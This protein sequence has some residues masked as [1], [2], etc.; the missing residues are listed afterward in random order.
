MTRWSA[1][2]EPAA[3]AATA[4][5]P[6]GAHIDMKPTNS[7]AS[8][9]MWAGIS[10]AGRIVL[11]LLATAA[12]SR[13]LPPTDFGL[14]AMATIVINFANLLRDMGTSAAVIQR[15]TLSGELLDSVFWFNIALGVGLAFSV[16]LLAAPVAF[17]F[18]EARLTGVLAALAI[19]FPL[20]SSGA[21]HQALL[22]RGMRFRQL[23]RIE[24]SSAA[25]ALLAA[26]IAARHGLG[27]YSL[28]LNTV[29]LAALTTLQL[30]LASRWRPTTRWHGNELRSLWGFSANL[31]GS[32]TLTYFTRNIDTML[33]GRF[34]GALQLGWYNTAYRIMLF[35]VTNLSSVIARVLF[36]V[37][38]RRQDNVAAFT[39]LYL[40]AIS[41]IALITAPL[42]TGIWATRTQFVTVVLGE[43]W[44]PVADV[45]AW[46]APAGM[47]QAIG[48]T[49]GL[50]GMSTGNTRIMMRW[51]I[52]VL[53]STSASILI[54]L[55]WGYVGVA[56]SYAIQ[57]F[58]MF[59][60]TFA[61]ALGLIGLK[62][63]HLMAAI[64]R[65][66]A[67]AIAMAA[68]VYPV[69]LRLDPGMHAA[70]QFVVLVALGVAIYLLLA[71][72]FMRPL[73]TDALA[74]IRLRRG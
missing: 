2:R 41:G 43:R 30:W 56:A 27:V 38:S 62:L 68:V 65:Q 73:M 39:T 36:P 45:I 19:S 52:V 74:V 55:P 34:L 58:I 59:L 31:V 40:R 26:V 49:V 17:F 67:A 50:I 44:L 23:A 29:C 63:R 61:V 6:G 70:T 22:E 1:R 25:V 42:M 32:Q 4:A 12:L 7:A 9:V 10:Q 48:T 69:S 71:G 33:I 8:G 57:N 24:L 18:K 37:L 15:H 53:I 66:F 28:V 60:P 47:L 16:L 51:S 64:G 3:T 11:Q 20:G 13:L 14:L 46:L 72:L 35:P 54:G 21:V 5:T